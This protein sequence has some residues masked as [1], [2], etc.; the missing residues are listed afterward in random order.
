LPSPCESILKGNL[1]LFFLLFADLS[2]DICEKQ[3]LKLSF[4]EVKSEEPE[5]EE[6]EIEE[7]SSLEML[8]K[9]QQNIFV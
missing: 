3:L 9:Q 2:W 1:N 7:V 8:V 4:E 5:E 6:E